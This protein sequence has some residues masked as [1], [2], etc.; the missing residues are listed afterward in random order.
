MQ[1]SFDSFLNEQVR[2]CVCVCECVCRGVCEC[3][4]VC[5]CECARVFMCECVSVGV[6]KSACLYESVFVKDRGGES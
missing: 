1:L 2:K 4:W 5:G 3:V 6:L